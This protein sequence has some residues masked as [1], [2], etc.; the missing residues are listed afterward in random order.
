MGKPEKNN[1]TGRNDKA[2]IRTGRT[3]LLTAWV[4]FI[5]ALIWYEILPVAWQHVDTVPTSRDLLVLWQPWLGCH[6][7]HLIYYPVLK[8][9]YHGA[10]WIQWLFTNVK[11]LDP[12]T[13]MQVLNGFLGA[14]NVSLTYVVLRKLFPGTL[15]ALP[16]AIACAF[17]Y[18]FM[19]FA[20]DGAQYM[21]AL[22][23]IWLTYLYLPWRAENPGRL[24]NYIPSIITFVIACL[25]HQISIFTISALITHALWFAGEENPPLKQRLVSGLKVGIVSTLAVAIPYLLILSYAAWAYAKWG[26]NP[27]DYRNMN[28]FQVLVYYGTHG[29]TYWAE[30]IASGFLQN[31]LRFLHLWVPSDD[32]NLQLDKTGVLLAVTAPAITILWTIIMFPRSNHFIKGVILV[33]L[34]TAAVYT[35]FQTFYGPWFFFFKLFIFLPILILMVAG[36]ETWRENHNGKTPLAALILYWI[37][38][39][40]LIFVNITALQIEWINADIAGPF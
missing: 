1:V 14:V 10:D 30:N 26:P 29:K 40:V 33:V 6:P 38:V 27:E 25:F 32:R 24:K 31:M 12:L 36:V 3:E 23:W 39:L 17:A 7:H 15:F 19:H 21:P 13:W 8:F 5:L 22:I 4:L 9:T 2:G 20:N 16:T 35:I 37:W 28:V 18:T 34:S 11:R